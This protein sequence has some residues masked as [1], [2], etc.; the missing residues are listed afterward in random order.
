M[1]HQLVDPRPEAA[2]DLRE[3]PVV[4]TA[5]DPE[6]EEMVG[7]V[8]AGLTELRRGLPAE[9]GEGA[10]AESSSANGGAL[11]GE[12]DDRNAGRLRGVDG[13]VQDA[14]KEV[15]VLMAVEMGGPDPSGEDAGDLS[16][17]L[18]AKL[19]DAEPAER[20]IPEEGTVG[21]W[22]RPIPSG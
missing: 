22:E 10:S 15:Q 3:L 9:D 17:D 14:G 8:D 12:P 13:D 11:A 6:P 19:A 18:G 7:E 4:E 21:W 1:A 20:A 16:L 5:G 2:Q